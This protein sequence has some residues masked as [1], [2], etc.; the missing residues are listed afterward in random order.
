M[1]IPDYILSKRGPLNYDEKKIMEKHTIYAKE[2]LSPIS[3]LSAASVISYC[4][5]ERWDGCGYPQGLKGDEIPL[6][7]RLFAVVDQWDAL[8]SEPPYRK[9]WPQERIISYIKDNSGKSFDPRVVEAFLRV[10]G[11]R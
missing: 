7:A 4:H 10:V 3:F 1:A 5:H 9:A 2:M 6:S 11:Q 8:S